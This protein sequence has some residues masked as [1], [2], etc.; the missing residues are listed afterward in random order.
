MD[1]FFLRPEQRTAARLAEAGGNVD[2]ERFYAEVLLPLRR[3]ETVRYRPYDCRSQ[4]LSAPVETAPGALNIVEGAYSMHPALAEYYDLSAFLR[5]TPE[6]QRARIRARNDPE[7]QRRFFSDWIP[8]EE[9]YFAAA[10]TA[11]R[12]DLILEVTE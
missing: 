5:V 9:A 10:D 6:M 11:A 3:G 2:R 7:A 1:D 4:T 8:M 12:C